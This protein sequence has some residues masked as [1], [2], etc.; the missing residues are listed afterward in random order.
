MNNDIISLKGVTKEFRQGATIIHALKDITW[1]LS[2]TGKM[3]AVVGPSGSGKTTFLNL[4]GALDV[5]TSGQVIVDGTNIA[6]L[7]ER[8]LTKYRREKVG[9]VFQNYNLIPNLSVLENIMLPMEFARTPKRE[10][11]ARALGFLGDVNLEHRQK[12]KPPT[13]SGGEQQRVA[14]AR[15]LANDPDIIL[16]DEPTGNLDSQTGVEIIGLLKGLAH[17]KNKTVIIITHDEGIVKIADE[18]FMLRNS[19]L[20]EV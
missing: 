11:L 10:A 2:N 6:D 15:S 17:S 14:I 5:P 9:F 8:E 19:K 12:Q 18:H 13:L 1:N 3:V 7:T 16:A 4:V 20:T